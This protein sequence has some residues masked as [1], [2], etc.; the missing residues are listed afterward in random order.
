MEERP[1]KFMVEIEM[2]DLVEISLAQTGRNSPGQARAEIASAYEALRD[3]GPAV[4]IFG[5]ARTE[6]SHPH[7]K[8]AR[9]V[10]RALGEAGYAII[11]GGGPGIMEAAN[12]GAK[13][14]GVPSVGLH[15]ELP[16]EQACNRYVDVPVNF[17]YFFTRK[18]FYVD[19][20]SAFV[21][22]PGGAGTLDELFE[23]MTLVQT[24]KIP[25]YPIII[26][27]G[28]YWSGL[29]SWLKEQPEQHGWLGSRDID[30][31]KLADTPED[32]VAEI[33]AAGTPRRRPQKR[34]TKNKK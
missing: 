30:S 16:S 20:A 7:Y 17:R 6:R 27:P 18:I 13:D 5:S 11:T 10:A 9:E 26:A 23:A 8:L 24:S 3:L 14:A 2:S 29:K 22:L 4:S 12:R 19:P 33:K 21:A 34:T 15:I 32:V 25:A 28:E 31:L 1:K